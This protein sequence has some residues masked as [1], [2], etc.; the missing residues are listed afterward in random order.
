MPHPP[1]LQANPLTVKDDL[2]GVSVITA[3]RISA[4][5]GA[6]QV[7]LSQVAYALASSSGEFEFR[8]IGEFDL[9]GLGGR[10]EI[11]EVLWRGE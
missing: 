6:G 5:A 8:S 9:K 1:K 3:A 2:F 11:Y 4:K 7:L 10:N